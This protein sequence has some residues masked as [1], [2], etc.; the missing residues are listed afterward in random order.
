MAR[1]AEAPDHIRE[2]FAAFGPIVVKRM[3]GGGGIYADETMFALI[4]D[5]VIYLKADEQT[6]AAFEWEGLAPFTYG[7]MNKRVAMS[8]WRM[9]DRLYDDPEE[10]AQWSRDALAAAV[11][12]GVSKA[13]GRS[14]KKMRK[15]A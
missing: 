3:F 14:S 10:L 1:A 13:R 12:A 15:K 6:V 4:I 5:G 2:L 7:A 9:P 11:R 8:Y